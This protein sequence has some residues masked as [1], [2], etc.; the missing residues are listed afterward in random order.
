MNKRHATPLF[1]AAILP[2]LVACDTIRGSHIEVSNQTG[3]T[4]KDVSIA[5]ADAK[6]HRD[7]LPAGSV[8]T[9]RPRP[10]HD[11]GITISYTADGLPVRHE[12]GYA[13]P[14]L[15][16]ECKFAIVHEDVTGNCT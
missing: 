3:T 6:L 2:G 8:L 10:K 4:L 11:G 14:P 12:L 13:S 15:P 5:F 9:F 7:S 1:L 16:M